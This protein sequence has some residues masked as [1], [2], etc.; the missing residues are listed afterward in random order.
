MLLDLL[1]FLDDRL[2]VRASNALIGKWSSVRALDSHDSLN[3]IKSLLCGHSFT[4]H[5]IAQASFAS[6]GYTELLLAL[7]ASTWTCIALEHSKCLLF[8]IGGLVIYD[9]IDLVVQC[10]IFLFYLLHLEAKLL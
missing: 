7:A 6:T 2:V 4:L 9:L 3:L 1:H 10:S 5:H 8:V